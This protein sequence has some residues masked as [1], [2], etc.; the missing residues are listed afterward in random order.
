MQARHYYRQ[1]PRI[2]SGGMPEEMCQATKKQCAI[3]QTRI[4][5]NLKRSVSGSA[6]F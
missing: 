3:Y 5:N 2:I 6:I 4:A 1:K